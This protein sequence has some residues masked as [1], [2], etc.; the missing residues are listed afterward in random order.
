MEVQK[1]PRD[2]RRYGYC[3]LMDRLSGRLSLR[4][5]VPVFVEE[6]RS[7]ALDRE[8][9]RTIAYSFF[10]D[11]MSSGSRL[12][13]P[14]GWT[15]ERAEQ[16]ARLAFQRFISTSIPEADNIPADDQRGRNIDFLRDGWSRLARQAGEWRERNEEVSRTEIEQAEFAST[17]ESLVP[18]TAQFIMGA[19]RSVLMKFHGMSD[20][21]KRKMLRACPTFWCRYKLLAAIR[22][23]KSKLSENDMWDVEHVAS[24]TPYVDC[25]ACDKGTRHI[26][27]EIAHLDDRFD[28]KVVSKPTELLDWVRSRLA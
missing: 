18:Y 1:R 8:I 4:S 17:V 12:E 24:A 16:A 26:S 27:T 13:F 7:L 25:L 22:L 20:D 19:S 5:H 21:D 10:I 11:A 23:H 15:A 3:R 9:K 14:E 28:T 2:D 6:F